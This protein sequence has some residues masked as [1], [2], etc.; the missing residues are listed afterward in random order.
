V[1]LSFKKTNNIGGKTKLAKRGKF[2]KAK[3]K[4]KSCNKKKPWRIRKR[5]KI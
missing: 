5:M 2:N 1:G 3:K 4:S